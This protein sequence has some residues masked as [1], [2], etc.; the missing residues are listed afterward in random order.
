MIF[1]VLLFSQTIRFVFTLSVAEIVA[2]PHEHFGLV[3]LG[4]I[5]VGLVLP[6]C[7]R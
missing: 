4:R 3:W 6:P 2:T 5:I 1:A 7:F